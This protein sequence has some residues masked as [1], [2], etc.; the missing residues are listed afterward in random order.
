VGPLDPFKF[1]IACMGNMLSRYNV[2]D[3]TIPSRPQMLIWTNA[4][5]HVIP[6]WP[7]LAP[8]LDR[9]TTDHVTNRFTAS[10]ALSFCRFIRNGLTSNGLDIVLSPFPVLASDEKQPGP[11]E[12]RS[13]TMEGM[14]G[15]E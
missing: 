10:E 4:R 3:T 14:A 11:W 9:M 13:G 12:L 7:L 8:L 2:C 15:F 6:A 5:Q 1:D